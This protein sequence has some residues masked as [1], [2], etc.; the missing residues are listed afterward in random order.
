MSSWGVQTLDDE[1]PARRI[2]DEVREGLTA[3]ACTL[4]A[5]ALVVVVVA[6]VTKLAG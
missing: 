6:L 1:Q 4:G 3:S 2:R 5:S